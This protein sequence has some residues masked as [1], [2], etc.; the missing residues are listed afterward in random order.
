MIRLALAAPSAM[1]LAGLESLLAD[2]GSHTVVERSA[3]LESLVESLEGAEVDVV[4]AV[5]EDATRFRPFADANG[6]APARS[7]PMVLLVDTARGPSP[8]EWLRRGVRA[9]LPRDAEPR[10]IHAA[11]EAVAAGLVVVS[12]SDVSALVGPTP[13]RASRLSGQLQP[14]TVPLSPREREILS[15]MAE[16]LVNKII[17]AR[18]GISEHTV[19]THI[20]S[21]FQKLDA[22]TRAEAVAIGARSGVILL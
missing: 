10:E 15:L 18:L 14:A 4:V 20:A 9:V 11:V 6:D 13:R 12:A 7:L 21:I 17:A 3:R 22:E 1:L 16:G 8:N 19:K 2:D 5:V